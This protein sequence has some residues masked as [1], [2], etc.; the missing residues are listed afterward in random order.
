MN[1]R[2]VPF[3]LMLI[4]AFGCGKNGGSAAYQPCD[5]GGVVTIEGK[6]I[7]SG[8]VTFVPTIPESAGGHPGI[9]SVDADGRYRLGNAEHG[10][11]KQLA[12]GEYIVTVVSMEIDRSKGPPAP[13][14]A[15]PE[16]YADARES[17]L[18]VTLIPGEN[19]VDLRLNR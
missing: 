19:K 6:P 4:A 9:A 10:R 14:L 15:I 18:H 16:C 7:S 1:L 2:N 11:E 5:A 17:P 8:M 12:P 13:K 3:G